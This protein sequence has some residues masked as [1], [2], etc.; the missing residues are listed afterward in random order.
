MSRER[1]DTLGVE[2]VMRRFFFLAVVC[3]LVFPAVSLAQPE[4]PKEATDDMDAEYH[5]ATPPE[6]AIPAEEAMPEPPKTAADD[7]QEEYAPEEPSK[8][9]RPFLDGLSWQVL[10]SAFYR[11]GGYLHDGVRAGPYNALVDADEQIGYPYTNYNGFGLNFAG[12][13]VMYTGE[14]FALRLDLRFGTGAPLL[15]PI[16]PVKQAYASY[17]PT[18]RLSIDFGFFDTIFGAEVVDEWDNANYTRGALYFLRQPFNHLGVRVASELGK[19]VGLTVMV[20][21][22]GVYGGTSIN[23]NE[24]ADF[25]W[26]LGFSP[27]GHNSVRRRGL[28]TGIRE[29]GLFVGGSYAPSGDNGNR[30]WVSFHDI[31]LSM[32]FDWFH[33]LLNG[34]YYLN[35][36]ASD[37]TGGTGKDFAYGHSVAFIFDVA[38][39]WSIGA[40]GEH[41]SGNSLYRETADFGGLTTGTVTVRYKPIEYLVLSLEGR[42]EWATRDVYFSPS[43]NPIVDPSTGEITGYAPNKKQNYAVI[44]GVSAHIGN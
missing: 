15:T 34:D 42:G 32:G 10:A 25:S 44:L 8:G 22:G 6:R 3:G 7:I 19:I 23:D 27:D 36:H 5:D 20:T 13:D 17:L 31:V 38:D 18:E 35:T 14:K 4:A 12:G 30:D 9:E 33:L 2:V 1:G 40:R 39:D 37:Q 21:N 11:L 43:A 28:R 16:A 29:V 24:V 26:Q 41:L